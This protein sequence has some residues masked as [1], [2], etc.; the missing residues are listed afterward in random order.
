[1][2]PVEQLYI[3]HDRAGGLT[4]NELVEFVDKWRGEDVSLVYSYAQSDHETAVWDVVKND[5]M[6]SHPALKIEPDD[7]WEKAAKEPKY[8]RT[9]KES[10][11]QWRRR[12]DTFVHA[13]GYY[14]DN[15]GTPHWI[16]FA[17]G[18]VI[19]CKLGVRKTDKA[20]RR[21]FDGTDHFKIYPY[22]SD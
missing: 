6:S 22:T 15:R 14:V 20:G 7:R 3:G 10:I 16:F 1:M 2:K 21:Y 4:M 11:D 17:E 19:D 8:A 9:S 5:A 12:F 18:E 13:A